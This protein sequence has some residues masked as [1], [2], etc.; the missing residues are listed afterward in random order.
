MRRGAYPRNAHARG[1]RVGALDP[2]ELNISPVTILTLAI[3]LHITRTPL[4]HPALLQ[5]A[6]GL[7]ELRARPGE[8]SAEIGPA[9]QPQEKGRVF[10][11]LASEFHPAQ[12][13]E[14]A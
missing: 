1:L 9:L 13:D 2:S 12:G 14:A 5:A 3:L 8:V 7:G 10:A 11:H 6:E 4:L